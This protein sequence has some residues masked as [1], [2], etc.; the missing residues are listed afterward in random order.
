MKHTDDECWYCGV[1][2]TVGD[3][4]SGFCPECEVPLDDEIYAKRLDDEK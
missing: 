1:E 3:I 4:D 2:V